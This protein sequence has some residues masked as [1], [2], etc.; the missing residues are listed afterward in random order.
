MS[1]RRYIKKIADILC[2][3]AEKF[4]KSLIYSENRRYRY[5]RM[6]LFF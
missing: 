5:I 6:L 2:G 1:N 3:I 4:K